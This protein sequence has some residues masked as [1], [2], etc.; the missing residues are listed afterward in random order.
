MT[1]TS[2]GLKYLDIAGIAFVIIGLCAGFY[3]QTLYQPDIAL[4]YLVPWVIGGWAGIAAIK[5]LFFNQDSNKKS[6]WKS[7]SIFQKKLGLSNLAFAVGALLTYFANFGE[8]SDILIAIVYGF[9]LFCSFLLCS[10]EIVTK[11]NYS[12]QNVIQIIFNIVLIVVL[13]YFIVLAW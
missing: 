3:Q 4:H 5:N 13:V 10:W 11:K 9:F 7:N 2:N 1:A 6:H 12:R 8:N